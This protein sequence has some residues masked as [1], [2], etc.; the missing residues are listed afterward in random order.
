[1]AIYIY[2]I[3]STIITKKTCIEQITIYMSYAMTDFYNGL[4]TR[5]FFTQSLHK[6]E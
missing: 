5:V 4:P 2:T 6:I 3:C 1:M